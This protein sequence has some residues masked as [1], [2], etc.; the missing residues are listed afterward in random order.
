MTDGTYKLLL[1]ED[2]HDVRE[3]LG[4]TFDLKG[5]VTT[6]VENAFKA[7]DYLEKEAFDVIV[8]DIKMPGINGIEFISKIKKSSKNSHTSIYIVSGFIAPSNLE[9]LRQMGV[10]NFFPKPLRIT[11]VSD[12]IMAHL[13]L[14]DQSLPS[15]EEKNILL[16]SLREV[17]HELDDG[18]AVEEMDY[19]PK[20]LSSST[21]IF[22]PLSL[23]QQNASIILI[24]DDSMI[25]ILSNDGLDHAPEKFFQG[26]NFAQSLL[27]C[28]QSRFK[29]KVECRVNFN[30][31]QEF[32]GKPDLVIRHSNVSKQYVFKFTLGHS[33]G[34][35]S[36]GL[37]AEQTSVA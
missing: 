1:V 2:D 25:E 37:L 7:L 8:T 28:V 24:I 22:L 9:A 21:G 32:I 11:R 16:E 15:L 27:W 3:T 34:C 20:F 19:I 26:K 12:E 5:F 14:Q 10:Q 13:K 31:Q 29:E 36:I 30:E 18:F 4:E 23:P 17:L 33:I 6:T 35:L